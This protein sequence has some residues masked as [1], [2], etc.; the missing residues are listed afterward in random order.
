MLRYVTTRRDHSLKFELKFALLVIRRAAA[1]LAA[2]VQSDQDR[3]DAK[4]RM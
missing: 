1:E 4:Q 3:E 2:Q